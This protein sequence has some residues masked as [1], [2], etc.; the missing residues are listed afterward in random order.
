MPPAPVLAITFVN[1]RFGDACSMGPY[2]VQINA[3]DH[4]SQYL[5]IP[6]FSGFLINFNKQLLLLL[7]CPNH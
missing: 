4:L 6:Y 2:I 1:A 3:I 7:L 5:M